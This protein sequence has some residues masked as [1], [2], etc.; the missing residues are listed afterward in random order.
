MHSDPAYV[1]SALKAGVSGYVPKLRAASELINAILDVG[2]GNTYL[3][4]ELTSAVVDAML[5]KTAIPPDP[6]SRQ[7]RQVIQLV[8]EGKSTKEVAALLDLNPRTVDHY[9]DSARKKLGLGRS[10][11]HFVRYAVRKGMVQ[12]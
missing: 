9:R 4:P 10:T 2:N 11:A 12:P 5:A 7:E 1:L 8:A 3:S 6:L